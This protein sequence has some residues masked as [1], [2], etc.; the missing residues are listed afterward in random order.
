MGDSVQVYGSCVT[1]TPTAVEARASLP[2]GLTSDTA[3][4]PSLKACGYLASGGNLAGTYVVLME[5]TVTYV[6]MG[7]STGTTAGFS[8]ATGTTAFPTTTAVSFFFTVPIASW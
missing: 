1:G 3:K 5:P 7:I 2:S 4:I 6:T 8:K